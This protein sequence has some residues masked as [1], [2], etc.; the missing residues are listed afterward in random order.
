MSRQRTGKTWNCAHCGNS[1]YRAPSLIR[2][3]TP[4]CS[5]ACIRALRGGDIDPIVAF[6]KKVD[7]NGPNGCWVWT[8]YC[9]K[10]GHGWLGRQVKGV[11]YGY[12]AHRHAWTLLRGPLKDEDCLLHR[13]DNPPCVNPDHLYIGDRTDNAR[14]MIERGRDRSRGERNYWATLTDEQVIEIRKE[15]RFISRRRTNTR[16]LALRYGVSD[17]VI[18]FAAT[19]K[20]WKHLTSTPA[21]HPP[22]EGQG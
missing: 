22:Q 2:T 11:R 3:A 7:K 20:T 15:F 9:Q 16:E 18:Y 21:I 5:N 10:F 12:L 17:A 6:W 4:C 1:F 13:C 14:D 8:G 19:G